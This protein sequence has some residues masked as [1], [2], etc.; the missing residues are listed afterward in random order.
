MF[1]RLLL[2]SCLL[3][4]ASAGDIN[5]SHITLT[6]SN[7][8]SSLNFYSHLLGGM[9]VP[10]LSHLS[11]VSGE[12]YQK[13]FSEDSGLKLLDTNGSHRVNTKP[14]GLINKSL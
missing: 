7:L 4:R 1:L 12:V 13:I 10:D 5:I 2:L 14:A 8:N 9:L 3:L 6:V 11:P